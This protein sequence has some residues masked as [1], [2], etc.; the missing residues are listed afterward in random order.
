MQNKQITLSLIFHTLYKTPSH[1]LSRLL[2]MKTGGIQLPR[3][4]A[5]LMLLGWF[6]LFFFYEFIFFLSAHNV[7][8]ASI[9]FCLFFFFFHCLKKRLLR[10]LIWS[11]VGD[12]RGR[13]LFTHLW[14]SL[15][16]HVSPAPRF[17]YILQVRQSR[18]QRTTVRMNHCP[19]VWSM[20]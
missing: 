19:C 6:F 8:I 3:V 16:G 7:R 20:C 5:I 2:D 4:L 9:C 11:S 18:I 17:K 14:I 15:N 10:K 12:C 13:G 1:F